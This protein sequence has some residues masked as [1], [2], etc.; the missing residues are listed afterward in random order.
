MKKTNPSNKEICEEFAKGNVAFFRKYLSETINWNILGNGTIT[1]KKNVM[2]T[3][4]M[5]DFESYPVITIKT[6]IAEGDMV[7]IESTGKAT[8]KKGNPYY[9]TY[10][11]VYHL[12]KGKIQECTT[13]LDTALSK[14]ADNK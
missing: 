1:G 5:I 12:K 11:D 10:C 2:D 14:E 7:V 4:G 6:V 9:Q 8:T 13:Y 3:L